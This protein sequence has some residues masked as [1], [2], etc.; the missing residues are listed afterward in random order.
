MVCC[1]ASAACIVSRHLQ[2]HV[3][4]ILLLSPQATVTEASLLVFRAC[5]KLE[6]TKL[7]A[8]VHTGTHLSTALGG[9]VSC[10]LQLLQLQAAAAAV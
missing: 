5:H 1:A 4:S 9:F 10:A 7:N 2:R 6:T 8:K 3:Q